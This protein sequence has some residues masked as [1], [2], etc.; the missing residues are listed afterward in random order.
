MQFEEGI[1]LTH[2]GELGVAFT[3]SE[4]ISA[5]TNTTPEPPRPLFVPSANRGDLL[6]VVIQTT[7][8]LP[9]TVHIYD[10]L[11]PEVTP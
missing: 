10:L 5:P 1:D 8:A 7:Q 11:I 4:Q 3:G 2:S 6:N 9:V